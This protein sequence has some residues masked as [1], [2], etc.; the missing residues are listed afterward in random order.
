VDHHFYDFECDGKLLEQLQSFLE[1]VNGTSV[2]KWVNLVL[3][4]IERKRESSKPIT[5]HFKKHSPPIKSYL[6]IPE[7]NEDYGILTVD[8]IF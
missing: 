2:Q 3:K 4:I 5:L 6:K 1:T 7:N 8:D